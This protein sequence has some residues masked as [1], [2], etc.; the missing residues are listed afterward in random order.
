MHNATSFK[1]EFIGD[2][3]REALHGGVLSTLIDTTGG[4]CCWSTLRHQ[5]DRVSTIDLR[6]DYLLKGPQ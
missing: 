5:N 2:P 4:L 6:I 3:N 1:P